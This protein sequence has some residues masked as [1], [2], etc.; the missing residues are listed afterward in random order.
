MA[1]FL[2][3]YGRKIA[4][5]EITHFPAAIQKQLPYNALQGC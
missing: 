3:D 4:I 2:A 1:I 5:S